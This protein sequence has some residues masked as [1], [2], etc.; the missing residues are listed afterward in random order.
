M[1]IDDVRSFQELVVLHLSGRAE[2]GEIGKLAQTRQE[3]VVG[4]V[5][6]R[7]AVIRDA[8]H[9]RE[10]RC[11]ACELIVRFADDAQAAA[12]LFRS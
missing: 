6:F 11:A 4:P 12:L 5:V 1:N 3:R 7:I 9:M 8:R 10:V 2:Q